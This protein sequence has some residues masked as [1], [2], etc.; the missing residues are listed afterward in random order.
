VNEVDVFWHSLWKSEY[1][2]SV[3]KFKNGLPWGQKKDEGIL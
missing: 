1:L 2:E 3:E